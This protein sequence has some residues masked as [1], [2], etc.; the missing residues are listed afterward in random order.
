MPTC[1]N[2]TRANAIASVRNATSRNAMARMRVAEG[3][4]LG[5]APARG[6]AGGVPTAN[7]IS[8][9]SN[10][11]AM[12]AVTS[13]APVNCQCAIAAVSSGTPM[14]P[15]QLAPFSARL[16]AMPRLRSNHRPSV[17][18]MAPRLVPAQPQANSA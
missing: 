10:N 7:R 18:V 6:R 9:T 5:P 8:G 4:P 17:L 14:M 1:A 11:S 15:P 16:M 3:L 13:M 2:S 12:A